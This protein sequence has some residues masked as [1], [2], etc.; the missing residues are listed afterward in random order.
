MLPNW[1]QESEEK[2]ICNFCNYFK[3]VCKHPIE[4]ED[5]NTDLDLSNINSFDNQVPLCED[6]EAKD[7]QKNT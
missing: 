3:G 4:C 2:E 7:D 5:C 6:C 1:A